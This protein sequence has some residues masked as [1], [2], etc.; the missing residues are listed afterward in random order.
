MRIPKYPIKVN[1]LNDY[2]I[3]TVSFLLMSLSKNMNL[4]PKNS[5]PTKSNIVAPGVNGV[6]KA[7]KPIKTKK[8][9]ITLLRRGLFSV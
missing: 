8:I 7:I 2:S 3:T 4:S 5:K 9:P 6:T 1:Y